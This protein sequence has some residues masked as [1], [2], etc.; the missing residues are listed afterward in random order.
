MGAQRAKRRCLESARYRYQN[1]ITTQ[2]HRLGT[3]SD[4]NRVAFTM[5][6]VRSIALSNS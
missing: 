3:S 1:R 5:D 4:W 6:P 2:I